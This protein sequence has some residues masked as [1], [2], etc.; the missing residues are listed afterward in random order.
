MNFY[1]FVCNLKL[2]KLEQLFVHLKSIHSIKSNSLY[3]CC[4][5][6]CKQRFSSFRSFSKHMKLE[7]QNYD[8]NSHDPHCASN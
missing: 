3:S 6:K 1:C 7:L 2:S 5:P 4:V 8:Q